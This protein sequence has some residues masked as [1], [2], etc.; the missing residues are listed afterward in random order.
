MKKAKRPERLRTIQRKLEGLR[1][2]LADARHKLAAIEQGGAP[3][4]PI[5]VESASLVELR[6]E[7]LPCSRCE[8]P[9][10]CAE[11]SAETVGGELLRVT[12]LVCRSCGDE[13][14][15]YFRIRPVLLN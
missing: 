13:R 2:K 4:Y 6:A 5:E 3:D 9:M 14:D 10:S 15:V 7:A 8:Q 12:H 11:H 1:D